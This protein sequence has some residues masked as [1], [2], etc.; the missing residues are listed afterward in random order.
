[1]K[2][3]KFLMLFVLTAFFASCDTEDPIVLEPV[4]SKTISNLHAPQ[5]GGQGQPVSGTFTKFDFE[6]GETTTSETDWDIAFRGTSIIVNGGVSLGTTDE[7][8]RTGSAAVYIANG[9]LASVTQVGEN[10]LAQDSTTGYAVPTGSG[11]GW[12]TYAGPP[13]HLITP[14]A[15]KVLVIRTSE[16]RFAKLEITSYYENAPT[17]P[18]AF[19]DAS[20]YYTF[21]YVYQ[22]NQGLITF[23]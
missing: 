23:E 5:S 12:Y 4:A 10:L 3:T 6:T 14:I 8:N 16:G 18:N 21:N 22:P 11:N 20:K 15:G 17:N 1:M 19:T 13:T 9:G 7:P 2:T